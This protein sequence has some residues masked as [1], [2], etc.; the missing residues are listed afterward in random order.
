MSINNLNRILWCG[1]EVYTERMKWPSGA[2][3]G[4]YLQQRV[5]RESGP[6][7]LANQQ[8]IQRTQ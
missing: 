1:F 8:A 6:K 3:K 2:D 7:Y 5:G 4:T